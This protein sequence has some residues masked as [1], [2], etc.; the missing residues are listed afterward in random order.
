M[1][2]KKNNSSIFIKENVSVGHLL[3]RQPVM[4]VSYARISE[5]STYN[6]TFFEVGLFY[7][8]VSNLFNIGKPSIDE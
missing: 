3:I 4:M 7:K 1:N 2:T 6:S 5:C 8:P